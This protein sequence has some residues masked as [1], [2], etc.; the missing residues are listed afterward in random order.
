MNFKKI[1]VL[2]SAVLFVNLGFAQVT[3]D[4]NAPVVGNFVGFNNFST[5]ALPI[6]NQGFDE[7]DISSNGLTKFAI[8][9]LPTWNGLNGLSRTDVQRTTMGLQ[10]EDSEAWSLL[11]LKSGSLTTGMRRSWMNVGTSYTANQDFLYV[12]LLERPQAGGPDLQ[13]DAVFAWGCQNGPT[14]NDNMRFIF[15]RPNFSGGPASSVQ[16]LETMRITPWGNDVTD[17]VVA[18]GDNGPRNRSYLR[19]KATA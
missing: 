16:G 14:N 8:T 7:I 5:I 9:E 1:L 3:D 11:H 6:Q 18:W 10:G 13:T 19:G 17:A 4:T 12:G 15:L 2:L